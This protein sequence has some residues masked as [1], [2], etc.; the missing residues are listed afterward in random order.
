MEGLDQQVDFQ[1][2]IIIII[3]LVNIIISICILE[4]DE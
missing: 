3:L 1:F 4:Q 2:I